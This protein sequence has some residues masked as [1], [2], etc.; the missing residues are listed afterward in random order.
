MPRRKKENELAL[1][2][3]RVRIV[4]LERVKHDRRLPSDCRKK[5]H[6]TEMCQG[7]HVLRQHLN[8]LTHLEKNEE[9]EPE[10]KAVYGN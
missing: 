1:R 7:M 8:L 5:D 9:S 6:G 3:K 4:A 10:K 2:M